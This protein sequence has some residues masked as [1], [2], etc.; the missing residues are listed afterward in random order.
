MITIRTIKIE[1]EKDVD[2]LLTNL[3]WHTERLK[4]IPLNLFYFFFKNNASRQWLGQIDRGHRQFKLIRNK[5]Q[6]ELGVRLSGIVCRGQIIKDA[7]KN[8]IKINLQPS[9]WVFLNI[10]GI[11][12]MTIIGFV[13]IPFDI[14]VEYWW[15]VLIWTISPISSFIFLTIDVNKTEDRL[16]EYFDKQTSNT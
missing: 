2:S 15:A 9:G 7:N 12:I 6:F 3:Q 8:L 14:L 13:L 10:L 4:I 11:T 1:T 16:I 5:G